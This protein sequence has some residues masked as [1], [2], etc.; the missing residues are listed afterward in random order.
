MNRSSIE[1]AVEYA[2]GQV[3]LA[4][5][6]RLK[7]PH[8]KVKQSNVWKWLN[9]NE[10]GVSAKMAIPVSEVIDWKVTPHELRPDLYPH[11]EDGLP[12]ERRSITGGAA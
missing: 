11:P 10:F 12:E 1:K 4:N 3:S 2:G 8:L 7:Y 9:T 5:K 6:L